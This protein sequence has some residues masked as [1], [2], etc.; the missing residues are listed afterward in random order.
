MGLFTPSLMQATDTNG[1]P[2]NGAK[3]KFYLSGTTT[4]IAVYSDAVLATSLGSITT[5]DSAG[6]FSP[7]YFDESIPVRA[8]L[9][10]PNGTLIGDND[11][12]PI[13]PDAVTLAEQVT[14]AQTAAD[15]AAASAVEAAS[16]ATAASLSAAAAQAL[17][18]GYLFDSA[19]EGVS[20]GVLSLTITGA[21]T[22]GANGQFAL[23]FSG[24]SGS[25][26]AG[27]FTVSGGAV[28]AVNLTKR[29]KSYTGAPTVS[30]AA[31]TG[32][33]GATVT[34]AI[35]NYAVPNGE[36]YL[37]KGSG[38]T[39]AT[40]YKNVGGVATSQSLSFPSLSALLVNG[41]R[42]MAATGVYTENFNDNTGPTTINLTDGAGI[43]FTSTNNADDIEIDQATA[44]RTVLYST[45]NT[46]TVEQRITLRC[47]VT[48]AASA[49]NGVGICF[50]G[51]A[52]DYSAY[53]Y[54]ANGWFRQHTQA[55]LSSL[56]LGL[57]AWSG[58]TLI[59]Y[60]VDIFSDGT[61]RLSVML[62]GGKTW[63][64]GGLT[65]VP[66]SAIKLVVADT[67]TVNFSM[68]QG[69]IPTFVT[70]EINN[71]ILPASTPYEGLLG[72]LEITPPASL[73]SAITDEVKVYRFDSTRAF[74]NLSLGSQL[75]IYDPHV[76]VVYV[77]VS[78]GNDAN[79]GT[80]ASPIKKLST[81]LT[82]CIG[83]KV[84]I[85]AN[86][87]T[88]NNTN[89][90]NQTVVTDIDQLEVVSWDGNPVIS[91]C[92]E[93]ISWT[94]D[95]GTTYSGT[96]TNVFYSAFDAATVDANGD[97]LRLTDAG[98]LAACR[99][100]TGS[101]YKTG[102]TVYI[103]LGRVPDSDVRIYTGVG[104]SGTG[105]FYYKKVGGSVYLEDV[106]V[107][108]GYYGA[109]LLAE[110]AGNLSYFRHRRCAF[111]YALTNGLSTQGRILAVGQE[112][113]AAYNTEDGF[114]YHYY[115]TPL[116]IPLCIEVDCTARSNGWNAI[117]TNNGS[118]N[119]DGGHSLRV[120]GTYTNNQN[121]Q[122]HDVNGSLT[123]MA[124]SA[125]T[126]PRAGAASN[127]SFGLSG[128]TASIAY[129]DGCTSSGTYDL[130]TAG[131]GSTIYTSNFTTN[132]TN[133]AGA[134][135]LTYTP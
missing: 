10:K 70:S 43:T 9:E 98:S 112:S 7:I 18:N 90:F 49:G 124:G 6:W 103:N 125:V 105:N 39:W 29:G 71:G 134:N 30:V 75:S 58:A 15:E 94:L 128:Y 28:T 52:G 72:A 102:T 68:T 82:R 92:Y 108:G 3:W 41:A 19:A 73:D 111:K 16:S 27:T 127:Y 17:A 96:H 37:V 21:G 93:T 91:T 106:E 81:A 24:G 100:T 104:G 44:A 61:A 13:A 84:K 45:L 11:I 48:A 57:D 5:S 77:D 86:G 79:P 55:G 38:N 51:G 88:Y 135:V 113:A 35:G 99:T 42:A 80:A 54:Q 131:T 2:V 85:M 83:G 95:T 133:V 130:E 69:T 78:T 53:Y 20:Q 101:Y 31:S 115:S 67:M 36:Y 23:A 117:G 123:W 119:H 4:P 110:T 59:E 121:R 89:G 76:S 107:H 14:A 63:H 129:L 12:D 97:Y 120:N 32:L 116:G 22:G 60:V 62:D 74:S 8:R 56:S 65:S 40:L 87:G 34:A 122:I 33:S 25:L 50:Y 66:L 132:G 26:A 126:A 1:K 114:V 46:A 64:F 47:D 109:Y 118:T